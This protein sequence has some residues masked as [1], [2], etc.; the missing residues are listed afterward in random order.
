MKLRQDG[1]KKLTFRRYPEV[2]LREARLKRDQARVEIGQGDPYPN[3]G[4]P[5]R[6]GLARGAWRRCRSPYRKLM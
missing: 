4:D 6:V 3:E 5:S 1:E 2:G